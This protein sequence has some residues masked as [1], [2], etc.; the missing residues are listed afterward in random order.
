MLKD[1]KAFSGYSVND[2]EAAKRFYGETLGVEVSE[3][4]AG[5][6]LELAGGQRV[7]MYPKEDHEPATFT[8]LNFQVEDVEAT[9]DAL[10][11]RGSG[12]SAMRERRSKPTRRRLPRRGAADRLVQGPFGQRHLGDRHQR[13]SAL[14]DD[15]YREHPSE[16]VAPAMSWRRS[17]AATAIARRPV[18]SRS[19]G[20][21]RRPPG[22]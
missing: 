17:C 16:F 6:G 15:L 2:L 8:V 18:A 19:C 1:T 22:F 3:N 11:E 13:L 5:L 7:F 4:P 12:S 21:P 10:T 20:G 9:V 14:L